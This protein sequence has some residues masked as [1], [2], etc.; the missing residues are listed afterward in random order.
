MPSHRVNYDGSCEVRDETGQEL[1]NLFF[2]FLIIYNVSTEKQ[3]R[4]SFRFMAKRKR[5]KPQKEEKRPSRRQQVTEHRLFPWMIFAGLVVG[6]VFFVASVYGIG[7]NNDVFRSYDFREIFTYQK[8]YYAN[9]LSSGRLPLWNPHTF[10]GWPFLANPLIQFFYPFS[11][12]FLFLPQATAVILDLILHLCIGAFGMYCLLR[13]TF[14][15]KRMSAAF[16]GLVYILSGSFI[17]HAYAG[18]IQFYAAALFTPL[19]MLSAD[20]TVHFLSLPERKSHE[21]PL[22][23]PSLPVAA[24]WLCTGSI[25]LALMIFSGGLPYVWLALMLVGLYRLGCLLT[26]SLKGWRAWGREIIVLGVILTAGVGFTAV[27]LLPTYELVNLSN[28]PLDN[29]DYAATGSYPPAMLKTFL[30]PRAA[31]ADSEYFWEYYGYIGIIPLFLSFAGLLHIRHDRRI[32]VI[33]GIAVLTLL[34]MFGKYS[35]LFPILWKYV[36]TFNLFRD[37]SRAIVNLNFLLVLLAASGLETISERFMRKRT[38]PSNWLLAIVLAVCA[39]TLI[40]ATLA[41]RSN[42]DRMFLA[43][44]GFMAQPVHQ[45]H[46]DILK[47]DRSWYRYWFRRSRFRQNHA[48]AIGARSIGGYDNM[49]LQRYSRFVHFM[50]DTPIV[51]SLVTIQTQ[52]TFSNTPSPFPFKILGVK[53]ADFKDSIVVD[54]NQAEMKRAWFCT[55]TKNVAN[56]DEALRY[57]RSDQ[58]QPFQEIVIEPPEAE[59]LKAHQ[60]IVER[61]SGDPPKD[62]EIR[63][64]EL[65][66]ENLTIELGQHPP[67]YL[68]LSEIFY[69]GWQA[70]VDGHETPIHRADSI[71]SCIPLAENARKVEVRYR[72]AT[73]KYGALISTVFFALIISCLVFSLRRN[74]TGKELMKE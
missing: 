18:H 59:K 4:R 64:T 2:H 6:I 33:A 36:P 55:G 48:F 43:D 67:G 30:F 21:K 39:I 52:K 25:I 1:S 15:L 73:L 17:A 12:L 54:P 45:Q 60:T 62:P 16:G 63:V 7:E 66:P 41:A 11:L 23:R 32:I 3:L 5:Q 19:L 47:R 57:M 8:E 22:I 37:P 10:S 34:F 28:R 51:P 58:F 40:D 31:L 70:R 38:I 56:E 50:T 74:R 61:M 26:S 20:R 14:K 53:Y 68:V 49:F 44:K 35:F 69:P 29:Y 42:R 46:E 71:I 24:I 9:A 72:P 27:Q 65:A 13:I